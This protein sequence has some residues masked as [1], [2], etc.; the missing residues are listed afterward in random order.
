MGRHQSRLAVI[1]HADVVGSTALVRRDEELAHRRITATLRRLAATVSR[2]GGVA[3][4]VRGDA[5]VAEFARASDAVCAAMVFQCDNPQSPEGD[6]ELSP[7]IRI[8]IAIGEVVVADATV[9][10]AGVVLAQR[11]EQLA[12]A[13]GVAITAAIR[14]ALPG[15]LAFSLDD[16]GEQ[17]LKG[18]DDTVRVF[19][20]NS[21]PGYRPP[22]PSGRGRIA[23]RLVPAAVGLVAMVL[24]AVF[25][26]RYAADPGADAGNAP[27]VSATR[28][29][30][31]VLPFDNMGADPD[32]D[33]FSDGVSQDLIT[34]LSRLEGITVVA[35]GSSFVYRDDDLPMAAIAEALNASHILDGAIRRQGDRVRVNV[36]FTD[37]R[38]GVELWAE[39][40]D[41]RLDDIFAVQDEIT[42]HVVEVLAG[43]LADRP[44]PARDVRATG[45]FEA[46]DLFLRGQQEFSAGTRDS[47]QRAQ[48]NYRRAIEL[49][50]EFARAYGSLGVAIM[51]SVLRGWSPWPGE[52]RDRALDLVKR[53]TALDPDSQE[54]Q[55]SLG[56]V[57]LYRS[58]HQAA[59]EAA[60]RSIELAPSYADGYGLL[61]LISNW[62]GASQDAIGYAEQGMKLDPHYTWDYPYNIG[63]A[64][65]SLGAHERAEMFLREALERNPAAL[66]AQMILIANYARWGRLDDAEWEV[67]QLSITNPEL[68]RSH[69][70][71]LWPFA[72]EE[73]RQRV[74]GDLQAAGLPE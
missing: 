45:N 44:G 47:L 54:V 48:E 42:G 43:V 29:V 3:R 31:A 36:V 2:Y 69:F 33:Y 67:S 50:P 24:A 35:R 17:S 9:T 22:Q 60:R 15:R 51:R 57:S 32:Q 12:A 8:G 25:A 62:I 34:G 53:A 23:R 55:W 68:T 19:T 49:D 4:E 20:V 59:L 27:G 16:L 71:D 28:P 26:W 13:G 11:V 6:E 46:Y 18:F 5:L 64:H 40:F 1:L 58:E 56:F 72:T 70:K 38:G 61:A 66:P 73:Q 10:G 63:Y 21:P 39:R 52:M 30:I 14:E 37:V 65:Y 41:R 74:M 7:G